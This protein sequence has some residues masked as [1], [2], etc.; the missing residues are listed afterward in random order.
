M[1]MAATMA[2]DR[3][4]VTDLLNSRFS[5]WTDEGEHVADHA[6]PL[7]FQAQQMAG[8]VGGGMMIFGPEVALGE[9]TPGAMPTIT[10]VLASYT[11]EGEQLVRFIESAMPPMGNPLEFMNDARAR[12]QFM[13][14]TGEVPT[15]AFAV[16]SGDVVYVTP[17]SEYQIMAMSA[18]GESIWALRVAWPRPPFLESS[19]ERRVRMFAEDDPDLSADDFEWPAFS[20]AISSTLLVDGQGR[21]YVFPYTR[22]LEA[23]DAEQEEGAEQDEDAD[24]RPKGRPVD[25]YSPGGDLIVAGLASGTWRYARGEYV[26]RLGRAPDS[27][28]SV[29]YRYRLV[30]NH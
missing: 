3:L 27:D 2:A 25:V 4:I 21:L 10:N 8:L 17:S 22:G 28:E 30:L 20:N 1:P 26:Y 9:L 12:I 6:T 16:G 19:K 13:I 15:P 7:G 11:A 23:N 14:D 24:E 5:V 29:V 18:S